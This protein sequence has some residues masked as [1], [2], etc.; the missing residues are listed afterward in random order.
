MENNFLDRLYKKIFHSLSDMVFIMEVV[1]GKRFKYVAANEVAMEHAD[2]NNKEFLGKVLEEVLPKN[3]AEVL[4]G[5]YTNAYLQGEAY[6]FEDYVISKNKQFYGESKLTVYYDEL[7]KKTYILSI[8]R[9]I[10]D[11][12]KAEEKLRKLAYEDYLTGLAN[13]KVFEDTLESC[14]DGVKKGNGINQAAVL[15]LDVDHFKQVNDQ[16]GHS[17]GDVLLKKIAEILQN[18]VKGNGTVARIGGDEFAIVLEVESANEAKNIAKN[19]LKESEEK[20]LVERNEIVISLSI[21][22]ALS[23]TG[24]GKT[25]KKHADAALY[26]AK[27]NGRNQYKFY[28]K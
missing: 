1:D 10:T 11:R 21:G 9:D 13:R 16:Y 24:R 20:L 2:L 5:H 23:S 18:N 17:V 14:L 28:Q 19:I 25:V 26:E 8:T 4:N 3:I 27:E 7:E 12:K 15:L 6:V 22:I